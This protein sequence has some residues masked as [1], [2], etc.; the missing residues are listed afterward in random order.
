M[1]FSWKWFSIFF[2]TYIT[3]IIYLFIQPSPLCKDN[4]KILNNSCCDQSRIYK[5]NNIEK[6]C[7]KD[8]C[9]DICCGDKDCNVNKC[10]VK[11]GDIFCK[12]TQ[13]CDPKL[14][15]CQDTYDCNGY[16]CVITKGGK[17]TE[18]TCGSKCP[19]RPT[20]TP[21]PSSNSSGTTIGIIVVLLLI[22]LIGGYFM[23]YYIGK[24]L[25][26]SDSL[27]HT[28]TTPRES[29]MEMKHE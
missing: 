13:I 4:Q 9:G 7:Q 1:K 29:E 21:K 2:F 26:P 11:C 24:R 12:D 22:C 3:I 18:P 14:G 10:E 15:L 17:Y 20:P 25:I 5:D 23:Y 8:L 19:K 28:H 27:R 6:C 16:D